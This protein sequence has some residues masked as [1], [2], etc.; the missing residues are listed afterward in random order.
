MSVRVGIVDSGFREDQQ[1]WIEDAAAFVIR[2]NQLWMDN[3]SLD[4]IN[5]GSRILDIIRHH[6]EDSC[7]YVAQVFDQ[8]GRTTPVQVAAAIEW[9]QEQEVQVINLSLG[10]REDRESLRDAV[11]QAVTAG[12]IISASSPARGEPVYPSA[13]PGVFRMTGDAR[14]SLEQVSSLQTEFADFGGHV[15]GFDG[16]QNA[17]GASLGCAH[18]TGHIASILSQNPELDR[19]ALHNKLVEQALYFG[20]ER[21]TR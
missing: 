16:E 13:Y 3:P 4:Q 12:I 2:D 21:R 5:H 11:Q 18:M 6:N 9:L 19:A 10:L 17:A 14:C 7:F 20:A 1:S 8:R 15:L